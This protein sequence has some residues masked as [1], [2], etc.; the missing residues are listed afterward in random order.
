MPGCSVIA[1][2][3]VT[4]LKKPSRKINGYIN[5]TFIFYQDNFPCHIIKATL[6]FLLQNFR[7][8]NFWKGVYIYPNQSFNGKKLTKMGIFLD[9]NGNIAGLYLQSSLNTEFK[10]INELLHK[11]PPP[12]RL[13]Y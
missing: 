11:L 5:Q 8:N 12:P 3:C 7:S 2:C 10:A 9:R 13:H 4:I 1:A 6:I